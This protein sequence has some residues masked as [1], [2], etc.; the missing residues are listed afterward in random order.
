M[1][2]MSL[3]RQKVR[4]SSRRRVD[5]C[6]VPNRRMDHKAKLIGTRGNN[7]HFSRATMFYEMIPRHHLQMHMIA[8]HRP[9]RRLFDIAFWIEGWVLYL[10]FILWND[11][12]SKR[13]RRTGS[14]CCFGGFIDAL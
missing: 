6:L 10:E 9:Y 11:E 12:C 2:M 13:R 5:H 3:E 7:I 14:G 4:P 1:F 8:R